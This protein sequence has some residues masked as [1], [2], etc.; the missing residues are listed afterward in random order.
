[1]LKVGK[2]SASLFNALAQK[3]KEALGGDLKTKTHKLS[4]GFNA[5]S[6]DNSGTKIEAKF[7]LVGS[8]YNKV[9]TA[10]NQYEG[11]YDHQKFCDLN[12]SG[13]VDAVLFKVQASV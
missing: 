9:K 10:L 8:T 4:V 3:T 1:M 11:T 7:H 5:P 2:H 13:D 6:P 12:G